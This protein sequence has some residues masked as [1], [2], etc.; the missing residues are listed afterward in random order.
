MGGQWCL[1]FF[2]L[3]SE[4]VFV[5]TKAKTEKII[6]VSFTVLNRIHFFSYKSTSCPAESSRQSGWLDEADSILSV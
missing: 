5:S 4:Y 2:V 1:P 3:L 6:L